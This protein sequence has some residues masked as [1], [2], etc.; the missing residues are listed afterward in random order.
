M[1]TPAS[2]SY[3]VILKNV[4]K[5]EDLQESSNEKK[6]ETDRTEPTDFPKL[7]HNVISRKNSIEV[8]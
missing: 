4:S 2:R 6:C 5:K 1:E 8:M 7:T 3:I